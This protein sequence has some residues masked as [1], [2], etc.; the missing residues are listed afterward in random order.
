LKTTFLAFAAF[1]ASIPAQAGLSH[2]VFAYSHHSAAP[3]LEL[4]YS[5]SSTASV[6]AS[7]AGWYLS[8]GTPNGGGNWIAGVCGSSDACSGSDSAFR[9]VFVFAIPG[10]GLAVTGAYLQSYLE[11]G[12]SPGYISPS[13]S[14]TYTMY[15]VDTVPSDLLGAMAGVGI[16]ADLGT[17]TVFGSRVF[18]AADNGTTV[19]V[20]LNAA[21]LASINAATDMDWAVGGD[22]GTASGVPEPGTWTM[23]VAGLGAADLLRRR[24]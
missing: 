11:G 4:T 8:T 16:Y 12:G 18:S 6:A 22:F 20:H 9:N 1:A 13:A 3:T 5:D 2:A 19:M 24:S 21:A 10:S 17:G 15:E 14:G 7:L 23:I